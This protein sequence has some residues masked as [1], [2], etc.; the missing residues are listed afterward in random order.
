MRTLPAGLQA[1]LDSGATN[2]CWCWRITRRDGIVFGFTDHDHDLDF[3]GTIFEAATGFT[4]SEIKDHVG[5]AVDNL[6][7][8][9]ALVSDRLSEAALSA[10]DF[11]DAA[12]D[13]FRVNWLD[14][15]QRICVRTG[16]IG[17]VRRS[18][19]SFTAEIRGLAHY[20]QQPTGRLFQ[21]ACDAEVG[22]SRCGIDLSDPA[23]VGYGIVVGSSGARVFGASGLGAFADGWF[24]RGLLTF[25]GGPNAGRSG[26]V[27]RH[28]RGDDAAIELW[29]DLPHPIGAGDTF[30]ITAGCDKSLGTCRAKFANVVNFRG[31]PHMPGNDFIGIYPRADHPASGGGGS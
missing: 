22:D 13:I 26:E 28:A 25:T 20:L 7:V 15:S 31:F 2:L 4:A 18:G 5:L 23:H 12:V 21:F 29:Q 30:T 19:G 17:E 14:A 6:E 24:S 27:K 11:D 1:H 3:D 16:S 8:T 9:S 10:G